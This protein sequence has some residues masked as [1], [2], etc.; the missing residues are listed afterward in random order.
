MVYLTHCPVAAA[1]SAAVFFLSS[2]V[3]NSPGVTTYMVIDL[4]VLAKSFNW[5]DR[6]CYVG[7]PCESFVSRSRK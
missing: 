1:S 5:E 6:S 7:N 3:G 2:L 4:K